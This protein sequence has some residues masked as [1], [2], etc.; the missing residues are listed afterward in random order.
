MENIGEIFAS[1]AILGVALSIDSFFVNAA[2]GTSIKKKKYLTIII[3]SFIF[4]IMHIIM[5]SIG[6][7]FGQLFIEFMTK[8]SKWVAFTLL[9]LIGFKSLVEQLLEIHSE[10]MIKKE[11]EVCFNADKYI[12]ELHDQG[13]SS[14]QIKK[15]IKIIGKKLK[16]ND[17]KTILEFNIHNF[18]EAEVLGHYFIHYSKF[19]ARDAFKDLIEEKSENKD[20]GGKYILSLATLI[21]AQSI[22]TSI[23]ALAAGF[24]FTQYNVSLAYQLFGVIAGIVLGFCLVGGFVGKF[25]GEKF[26]K[27]ANII[28]SLVL[29]GLGIKALF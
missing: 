27:G 3:F 9:M 22:A 2:N 14:K 17:L 16:A 29:I 28:S 5:L 1:T 23:D 10:L 11:K 19:H 18:H 6:Y 15:K 20:S 7:F 4:A 25:I 13:L 8:Y 24:T 21:L 26:E 12:K